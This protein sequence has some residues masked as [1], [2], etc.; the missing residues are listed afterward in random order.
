V[1]V[2]RESALWAVAVLAYGVGDLTTT[3]LGLTAGTVAE[4]GPLAAPAVERAG[5]AG[6]AGLKATTLVAFYL[7]WRQWPTPRRAAIP[8]ALAVVGTGVTAWNVWVLA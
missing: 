1:I 8:I 3:W 6:L 5:I 7:L 2:D 4:A